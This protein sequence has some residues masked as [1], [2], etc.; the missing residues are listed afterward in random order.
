[1]SLDLLLEIG[2]ED[3]PARFV[4]AALEQMRETAAKQLADLRLSYERLETL[5]TPRRLALLVFG[6]AEKQDDLVR[7]AKGPAVKVAFDETGAPTKAALGFARSQGVAV[8]DLQ[9]RETE[10]GAYVFAVSREAGLPAADVV[11]RWLPQFVTGISFP[12]SMRWGDGGLR[13]AR[14]IRWLVALLGGRVLP[15]TIEGVEAGDVTFGHRF[16]APEPLALTGPSEYVQRLREAYV[17]VDGAERRRAVLEEVRKAAAACGGRALEDEDLVD[18]VTNLVEWPA[19]VVGSFDAAYLELP[20]AVLV[21]PMREHQR[22]FPLVDEA[23]RLLPLFVAVSNG[24]R[25]DM[26][27]IR[28]GNEKVLAA[29]LADARFFYDED[30]KQPLGD[31]VPRLKDVVFQEQLGSVHE[32]MERVRSLAAA[33]AAMVGADEETRRVLDRAA[34]L[35][36]ADLVTLMV[37]EFP[38]LQGIMGRE[39]ALL[40]GEGDAVAE[41]VYEHYLPRF[42]GDELPRTTAGALLSIAD[43]LDTMVGCFGIDLIPTGS[44]DPYALR[45]QALGVVRIV[46]SFPLDLD[47]AQALAAAVDAYGGRFDDQAMLVQK[48]LDFFRQR[49]RGVLLEQGV[50]HDFVE[51]VVR[52]GIADLAAVFQRAEALTAFSKEPGFDALVTAYGRAANLAAKGDADEVD[53]SLF[54][55]EAERELFAQVQLVEARLNELTKAKQW[56]EALASLAGLRPY[57]DRL[58]DDVMV[59]APEETLRRNRL[60]LLRRTVRLFGQVADFGAVV[61]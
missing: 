8:E 29:R 9:V 55:A 17:Y 48:L 18:E 5:G 51:A 21:T 57:V 11:G 15:V 33:L 40:S 39:Y 6:L 54:E 31:Y 56:Q 26:S 35:C 19:A 16:L 61:A 27:L 20:R 60:A 30:R 7:E 2:T 46:N 43:K 25:D 47:L 13:F 12:K 53:A 58:F 3:L 36:K 44:Q 32:K 34:Y 50:R 24:P 42:A 28:R 37:Y 45:R 14:P 23:G 1:M 59:M 41:A 22:Y 52:A 10:Q 49:V 38:E 4:D